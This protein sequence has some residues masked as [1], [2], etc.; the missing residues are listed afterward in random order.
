MMLTETSLEARVWGPIC[1]WR[2]LL[3]SSPVLIFTGHFTCACEGGFQYMTQR[4]IPF[5]H[6]KQNL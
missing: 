1:S 4:Y 5:Q 2:R 3:I 6:L